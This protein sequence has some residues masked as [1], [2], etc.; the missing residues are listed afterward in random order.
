MNKKSKIQLMS[1]CPKHSTIKLYSVGFPKVLKDP[2]AQLAIAAKPSYNYELHALPLS[3]AMRTL[4]MNW[5][6]DL[7]E[8]KSIKKKPMIQNGLLV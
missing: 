3:S 7:V 8:I 1:F 4:C 2:L 6:Y 5:M